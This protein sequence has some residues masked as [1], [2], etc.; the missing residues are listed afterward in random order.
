MLWEPLRTSSWAVVGSLST[1]A[2]SLETPLLTVERGKRRKLP[3]RRQPLVSCMRQ[4]PPAVGISWVPSGPWVTLP[5]SSRRRWNL[6]G[7]QPRGDRVGRPARWPHQVPP[8]GL[9]RGLL[10]VGPAS[11]RG[12][13]ALSPAAAPAPVS[14][15][16][17]ADGRAPGRSEGGLPAAQGERVHPGPGAGGR[18]QRAGSS[19]A[20]SRAGHTQACACSD[21]GNSRGRPRWSPL[22]IFLWRLRYK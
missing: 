3:V 18:P 22:V 2:L 1:C 19:P 17:S 8:R 7:H 11:P 12:S 15:G 20:L 13:A 10:C 16:C 4:F 9:E 21:G 5:L 6:D 14:W